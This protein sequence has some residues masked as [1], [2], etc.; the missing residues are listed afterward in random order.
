MAASHV[1]R[2]SIGARTANLPR[3]TRDRHGFVV[4]ASESAIVPPGGNIDPLGAARPA[5]RAR[6]TSDRSPGAPPRTCGGESG[7]R[8][9]RE[10]RALLEVALRARER[11]RLERG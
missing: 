4:P 5:T 8:S 11:G 9:A 10:A 1:R 3:R 7:G 6:A 2:L